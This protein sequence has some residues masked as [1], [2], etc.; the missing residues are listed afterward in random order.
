MNRILKILGICVALSG[1]CCLVPYLVL[2]KAVFHDL[3]SNTEH[4]EYDQSYSA[5]PV[6]AV[7]ERTISEDIPDSVSDRGIIL[8]GPVYD[9]DSDVTYKSYRQSPSGTA[10]WFW[11]YVC[12]RNLLVESSDSEFREYCEG[13]SEF[14]ELSFSWRTAVVLYTITTE[15]AEVISLSE[16]ALLNSPGTEEVYWY[17]AYNVQ[18]SVG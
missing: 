1:L 5:P 16:V 14:G 9:P 13:F 11:E 12:D 8:R 2:Q 3:H 18:L 17:T 7:H 4:N 15:L 10:V 6:P